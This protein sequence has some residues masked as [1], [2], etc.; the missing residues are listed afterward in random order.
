MTKKLL[1]AATAVAGFGC[2]VL[3]G[4]QTAPPTVYTAAQAVAGRTAYQSSCAK[5]HTD[6]LIGR[7]GTGEIPEFLL[8]YGGKI[9]P[10]AGA[11]SAFAPFMTKWGPRTTK[12]LSSRIKEAIGGFP[13][14]DLDE[15]TYLNL[16]AYVLQANGARPGTQALTAATAV[17]IRSVAAGVAPR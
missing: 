9:P 16:T 3:T 5:C 8:P 6:T 1:V 2:L 10:L 12:D 7:D 4:Q 11:N 13:P 15:K 14:Q 17:E